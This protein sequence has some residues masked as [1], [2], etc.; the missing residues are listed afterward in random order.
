[1]NRGVLFVYL[2][3]RK[4]QGETDRD[5]K[6]TSADF[7]SKCLYGQGWAKLKLGAGNSIQVSTLLAGSQLL[8]SS[9]LPSR[10]CISGK[11]KS[12]PRVGIKP[13]YSKTWDMVVLIIRPKAHIM[14]HHI[15]LNYLE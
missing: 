7:H 12:K 6:L 13:R 1:M 11:L 5:S 14:V 2:R 4:R 3:G 15:S 9:L 10:D 8:E